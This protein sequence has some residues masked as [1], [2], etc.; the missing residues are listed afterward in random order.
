MKAVLQPSRRLQQHR[1]AKRGDEPFHRPLEVDIAQALDQL[2]AAPKTDLRKPAVRGDTAVR[3][4]RPAPA[5]VPAQPALIVPG[6][7]RPFRLASLEYVSGGPVITRPVEPPAS[8]GAGESPLASR[9][10]LP[11]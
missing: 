8:T 7:P 9:R 6:R 11:C 4:E 5:P 3:P 10:R 2:A 1:R